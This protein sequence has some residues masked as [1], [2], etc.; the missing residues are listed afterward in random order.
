[1]L[2]NHNINKKTNE[3]IQML[4]EVK[5][6]CQSENIELIISFEESLKFFKKRNQVI[7]DFLGKFKNMTLCLPDLES[8]KKEEFP[9]VVF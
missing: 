5:L 4:N 2:K 6:N 1:M 3:T 7:K 9:L 8:A